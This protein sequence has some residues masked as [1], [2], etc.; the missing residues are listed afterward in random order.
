[1]MSN[2]DG[3]LEKQLLEVDSYVRLIQGRCVNLGQTAD[4]LLQTVKA[5][6]ECS[7]LGFFA[8]NFLKIQHS[9]LE[10]DIP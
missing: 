9:T 7:L 1:M 8:S 3:F 2:A 5:S 4:M 6:D 10:S